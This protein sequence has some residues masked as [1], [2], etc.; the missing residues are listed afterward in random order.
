MRLGPTIP[1]SVALQ[2]CDDV[3]LR[4][5]LRVVS[6]DDLAKRL[7][8]KLARLCLLEVEQGH[9]A[10]GVTEHLDHRLGRLTAAPDVVG[11][12]LSGDRDAW[13]IARDIDRKDRNAG[14]IRLAGPPSP[15]GRA[16]PADSR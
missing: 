15:R 14:G 6:V 11:G 13:L 12:H 8:A 5:S 2:L 10:A 4:T 1:R 7:H 16:L 3:D 9:L